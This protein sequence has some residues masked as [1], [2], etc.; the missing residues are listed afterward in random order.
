[1]TDSRKKIRFII[2]PKSGIGKQKKIESLIHHQVDTAHFDYDICYTREKYHATELSRE[3]SARH[4]DAVIAVGGDGTINEVAQGLLHSETAMG[5]IP[6]GS[7]NGLARHLKIPIN[8]K[9]AIE[10]IKHF[11]VK[12]IDTA[13][14]NGRLFVSIA[15][16]G[17]DSHV[18]KRFSQSKKRGFWAYA[19]ICFLE[20]IKYNNKRFRIYVN[21]QVIKKNAFMLSF[22]NSDQFG[23]NA[24][25]APTAVI[26]DGYLDLCIVRKPRIYYAV[27]VIPFIFLGLLHK[28]PFLKIIRAK[29]IKVV[30]LKNN[31][32]HIDGDEID[33]GRVIE[34]SINPKSLKIINNFS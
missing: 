7:G 20:Y 32:A 29:E 6:A 2:N 21:D 4:Y 27:F 23:F 3:A 25:I 31:I 22:A 34:V 24:R 26:D 5:I 15:G 13:N 11:N 28:T 10:V 17:F 9:K 19:R 18:A 16:V 14:I 1:M 33:L 12:T 8:T 30:Q